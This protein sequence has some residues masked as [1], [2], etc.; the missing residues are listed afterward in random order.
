MAA[1]GL[2]LGTLV[3]YRRPQ[4]LFTFY[5]ALLVGAAVVSMWPGPSPDYP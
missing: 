2:P 4:Q 5:V 1:I 3:L